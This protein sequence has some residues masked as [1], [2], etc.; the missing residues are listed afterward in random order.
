[1]TSLLSA[2]LVAVV[3]LTG[4]PGAAVPAS[5]LSTVAVA[6][7][8]SAA[9]D[10]VPLFEGLGEHHRG[11]TTSVPEAQVY[12]DQ[13]LRFTYAF[14]HHEAIR[15]FE[16][17]ARLDPSCAMCKW[18]AALAWGPN[19]NLPMDSTS[20]EAAWGALEEARARVDNESGA[21]RALIE[22]LAVRYAS[23][24][25]AERAALDSAYARAMGDY[26]ARFPDDLDG[27]VLYAESMMLL[28][29]W[30]YWTPE[31]EP[32]EG[33]DEILG[34]LEA[35]MAAAP[36]HP[37][38]CHFYIHAVEAAEPERAVE[39]AERLAGLMPGAGHIVHMPGH[40]YVRVGR[41]ADVVETN[42]HAV[43]V[44]E[45]YIADR[46]PTGI[47]TSAYYPHNYHFMAFGAMMAG[48]S[49]QALHAAR[50][51][52]ETID[53]AM[54]PEVYFLEQ[55][56]A[57]LQLVRVTFGRWEEVLADGRPD[58][59]HLV[60]GGMDAYARG[61]ALAA[62]GRCE[63]AAGE[64][65][66]LRAAAAERETGR[67]DPGRAILPIA[68]HALQGEIA[69]R[70]GSAEDAVAHF[71]AA[72]ELEDVMQYDEPPLWYYPVRQSLGRALLEA[73]RPAEAETAY[74]SDL[75]KFPDNAWSLFGLAE[76]LDAQ[77]KIAEAAEAHARFESAWAD[78][79]VTLSGSRF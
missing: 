27:A 75:A 33:T 35:T 67:E 42:V 10:T 45:S 52:T 49:A 21:E 17:A 79:D 16:E 12:F 40:I 20:A 50:R 3:P 59:A 62:T 76:A 11:I 2:L 78:A 72:A 15:S 51:L 22:A 13:G 7:V 58:P 73:G 60:A 39:C 48:M 5:V 19:I 54:V 18:G 9:T 56:P 30:D 74:R 28:R 47:Y 66:T 32:R 1:M 23:S 55:M 71:Q 8:V 61:T 34:V 41:Y 65:E 46:G 44:D 53:P 14:N 24:P 26:H 38:A 57:Y 63:E 6:P 68:D 29:P 31:G 37:G 69:L 43:H 70:C 4:G 36:E 64:L 25:P 77:G